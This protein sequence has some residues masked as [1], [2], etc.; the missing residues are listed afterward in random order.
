M[1]PRTDAIPASPEKAN[2]AVT[3]PARAGQGIF[4]AALQLAMNPLE[5][6]LTLWHSSDRQKIKMSAVLSEVAAAPYK[7]AKATLKKAGA[8]QTLFFPLMAVAESMFDDKWLSAG[9]AAVATAITTAP[10]AAKQVQEHAGIEGTKGSKYCG[11]TAVVARDTINR[12]LFFPLADYVHSQLPFS[13][14][15]TYQGQ[16]IAGAIAGVVSNIAVMPL[17]GAQRIARLEG[18]NSLKA[19]Q[20]YFAKGGSCLTT[21]MLSGSRAAFYCGLISVAGELSK[22]AT[23]GMELSNPYATACLGHYTPAEERILEIYADLM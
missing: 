10:L 18:L 5:R 19:F 21:A 16:F 20:T 12:S 17:D 13:Q 23:K 7:G 22:K 4:T 14:Q 2:D 11:T 9:A 1:N 8:Q 6:M 15:N 3:L